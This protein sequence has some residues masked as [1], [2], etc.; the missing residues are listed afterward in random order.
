M[1]H[2][3]ICEGLAQCATLSVMQTLDAVTLTHVVTN[4]R[5]LQLDFDVIYVL[6]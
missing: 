2:C 4:H 3:A 6:F 1:V 5:Q